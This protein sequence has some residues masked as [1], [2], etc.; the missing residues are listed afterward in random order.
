[1]ININ[2][3]FN[4]F[5]LLNFIYFH[6]TIFFFNEIHNDSL[7]YRIQTK[8]HYRNTKTHIKKNIKKTN[9]T[10]K[11]LFEKDIGPLKKSL[12]TKTRRFSRISEIA[13]VTNCFWA[14][15]CYN[16]KKRVIV[17]YNTYCHCVCFVFV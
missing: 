5:F 10:N 4:Y 9:K 2:D 14:Q 12:S 3:N 1:M 8:N 17:S 6:F 11:Q 13:L 16:L 7:F 15:T